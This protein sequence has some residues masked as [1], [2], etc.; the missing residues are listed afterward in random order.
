[1]SGLGGLNKSDSGVVIGLVQM[2]LPLVIAPAAPAAETARV[3]WEDTVRIS[4]G[5]S[6]GFPALTRHFGET[7]KEPA[8]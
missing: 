8:A 2:K 1:M 7:L 6:R 5:T 3:P 4:D